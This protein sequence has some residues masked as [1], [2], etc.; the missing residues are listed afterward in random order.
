M[1]AVESF[2]FSPCNSAFSDAF[3]CFS[4]L[5][6]GNEP[7]GGH[8]EARLFA[9][10]CGLTK[11]GMCGHQGDGKILPSQ[12]TV[13]DGLTKETEMRLHNTTE[14]TSIGPYPLCKLVTV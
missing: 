13:D 5:F 7:L 6:R 9:A 1:R 8:P 2:S 10:N 11:I 3:C 14:K 12:N 4:S